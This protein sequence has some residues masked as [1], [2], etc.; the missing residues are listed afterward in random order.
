MSRSHE[1]EWPELPYEAWRD[2][3]WT[4]H[5]YLQVIGKVRLALSP[6]EPEWAHVALYVTARGLNTS[7][8]P[9]PGGVFD[10]DVDFVDHVTSVRTAGGAV[11]RVRLEPKTVAEF[12]QELMDAM[13]RAGVGT[14]ISTTP[15]EV[16][17]TTP[18][19]LDIEHR[20]YEPEWA[21]RYWRALVTIDAVMKEH[22]ARYRGKVSPVHFFWGSMDLACTRYSGRLLEPPERAGVIARYG[23]DAE[24]ACSGFWPG[25]ERTKEAGFFAYT[26]P[27]P[28]GIDE[29]S[30]QPAA[31]GWRP[32]MGE[33][34][35]PYEAVRTAADPRGS[36][37]AFVESAFR[38][39]AGRAD[40][41]R[42]LLGTT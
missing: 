10:I 42:E 34:V 16:P 23:A 8:I 2:T 9:H 26:Y 30:V 37:L 41:P 21:N 35:L 27:A 28:P 17:F 14:E 7:P 22:R 29:A 4:L 20:T 1:D 19:P 39:G 40:W 33:F 6:R 36:L 32:D 15:S 31:A 11:E 18:Y 5:M 12:D 38:A 25:D 24:Q 13:A 3:K